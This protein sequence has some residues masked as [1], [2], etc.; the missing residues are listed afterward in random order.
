MLCLL[1]AFSEVR[2]EWV[3]F[4]EF[5]GRYENDYNAYAAEIVKIGCNF[6]SQ[7]PDGGGICRTL[8]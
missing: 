2:G 3:T 5:F 7:R 8:Y 6:K 4:S 1:R